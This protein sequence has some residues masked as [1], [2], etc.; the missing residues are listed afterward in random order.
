MD[1]ILSIF[2]TG[3]GLGRE[4]KMFEVMEMLWAESGKRLK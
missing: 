4:N 1:S 2:G 3:V